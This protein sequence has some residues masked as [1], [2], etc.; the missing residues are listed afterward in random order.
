MSCML[1]QGGGQWNSCAHYSVC[2]CAD[3]PAATLAPCR[4]L[5]LLVRVRHRP[6]QCVYNTSLH[7]VLDCVQ[8]SNWHF[9]S[10]CCCLMSVC[11]LQA[12]LTSRHSSATHHSWQHCR[13]ASHSTASRTQPVACSS[14]R[15][16]SSSHT[17]SS[18]STSSGMSS[19]VKS[20]S[21]SSPWMKVKGRGWTGRQ[22][23]LC[24][25]QR[26]LVTH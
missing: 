1:V 11:L 13:S 16:Y 8:T 21:S 12:S 9:R 2:M 4:P 26:P 22:R 7:G 6:C 19:T 18:S 24:P 3:Q 17:H 14:R 25:C 15:S 20:S 23:M 10:L 5:S